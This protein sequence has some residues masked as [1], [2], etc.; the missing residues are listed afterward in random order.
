MSPTFYIAFP[1]YAPNGPLDRSKYLKKAHTWA[2]LCG[3][4]VVA[5]PLIERYQAQGT[6]APLALRAEDMQRALEHDVIWAARGGYSAIELVPTLLAAR[7]AG[8]PLLIGYSDITVLHACWATGTWGPS[9]Y[10]TLPDAI[11]ESRQATSM[12]A[13]LTGAGFAAS[14][15]TEAAALVLRAGAVQAPLFAACLVVLAGLCGTAAMPDLRGHIL[16]IEDT[17][18]RPYAIDFALNQLF[19]AGALAGIS[20]L[21]GGSFYHTP[22]SDYGGPTVD[23]VLAAWAERLAVPC[24]SRLPFGHMEDHMVLL[25]GRT[26]ALEAGSTGVWSLEWQTGASG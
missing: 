2:E 15:T 11:D 25:C 14:S 8:S 9:I 4:N 7:P 26:V 16:A 17:D 12:K 6:W 3:W 24:I 19:L 22:H 10:G 5:S 23:D 21:L 20:G 1:S 13:F 18:E